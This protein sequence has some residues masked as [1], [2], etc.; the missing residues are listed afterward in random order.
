MRGNLGLI[1]ITVIWRVIEKHEKNKRSYLIV[2]LECIP[3]RGG[4]KL[5]KKLSKYFWE[6]DIRGRIKGICGFRTGRSP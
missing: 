3:N 4:K 1:L 2:G 6:E 5:E